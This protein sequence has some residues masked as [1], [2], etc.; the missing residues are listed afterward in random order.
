MQGHCSEQH[1]N[2]IHTSEHGRIIKRVTR[3]GVQNECCGGAT[4]KQL[5]ICVRQHKD[6]S[7]LQCLAVR[8]SQVRGREIT[9][10][11]CGMMCQ[12]PWTTQQRRALVEANPKHE[13]VEKVCLCV[14]ETD[15]WRGVVERVQGDI[16]LDI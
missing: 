14:E 7:G 15:G 3:C 4:K 10:K 2:T 9:G 16:G 13:I 6:T 5:E 12:I 11:P 1:E 8:R